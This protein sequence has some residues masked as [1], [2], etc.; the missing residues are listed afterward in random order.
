MSHKIDKYEKDL[1]ALLELGDS[2]AM[3]MQYECKTESFK[4]GVEEEL[5]KKRAKKAL[6]L[7]PSFK[8]KYQTWYSEAK[9]LIKQLLPD[10]LN[11]FVRYYEKPQRRKTIDSESY[12]IEDSLQGLT[13]TKGLMEI[14]VVEPSAAMPQLDQ[15]IAIL[16][17]IKPR[18]TSSLFE[19]QQ[20]VQA[21]LFDSELDSAKELAKNKYFRGAGAVAGVVIESHLAQVC[22]G[23]A[24][25]F[26]K[27][28]LTISDFNDE[29]KAQNI[30]DVPTWR[31]IQHLGDLRNLCDHKKTD[32]PTQ[33]QINDL[34]S[35]V[36][37]ITKT[38]F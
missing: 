31:F 15:Q 32:D 30:I 7:L 35:G 16:K 34:I 20:L 18:F 27:T 26:R 17:S 10:R 23:H 38:V 8:E 36:D 29:L 11:D 12:R 6:A 3:A 21:D 24:I 5:G 4:K 14:V 28:R 37:K 22:Q 1:D 25:K 19:I 9:V 13:I 2:L 33:E